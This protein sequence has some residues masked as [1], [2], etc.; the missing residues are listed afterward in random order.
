M[1][2]QYR[3]RVEGQDMYVLGIANQHWSR[4]PADVW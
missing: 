3:K 2:V 4:V 1:T